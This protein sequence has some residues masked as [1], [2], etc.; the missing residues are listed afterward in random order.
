MK[1][2]LLLALVL[3]CSAISCEDKI[4]QQI[5]AI[6]TKNMDLEKETAVKME[7]LIQ[8]RNRI[9]VQ[10]RA[11]T[12]EE[13]SVVEE[14]DAVEKRWQDWGKAFHARDLIHVEEK[15]REAFLAE[16][17]QLYADL[18]TLHSDIESMLSNPF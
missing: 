2:P 17:H 4:G 13:I 10:G 5:Q 15:D 12:E 16:Q 1:S 3:S 11:L 8:F 9:N 14:I 7:E 18:K 6:F